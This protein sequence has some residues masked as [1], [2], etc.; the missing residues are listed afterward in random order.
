[1]IKCNLANLLTA[2]HMTQ[3]QLARLTG[4]RPATITAMYHNTIQRY[5]SDNL[6]AIC[7]VLGCTVGDLV[8]YVTGDEIN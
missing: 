3:T 5:H 6:D 2:A 1:M 7:R 4:I 8:E